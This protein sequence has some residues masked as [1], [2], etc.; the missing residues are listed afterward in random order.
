M[1]DTFRGLKNQLKL[2]SKMIK[3]YVQRIIGITLIAK[4]LKMFHG[5]VLV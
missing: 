4:V 3:D 2:D 1:N 5:I